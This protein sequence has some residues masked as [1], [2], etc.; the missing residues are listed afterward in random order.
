[1]TQEFDDAVMLG[2]VKTP[3]AKVET[4]FGAALKLGI[5]RLNSSMELRK[6]IVDIAWFEVLDAFKKLNLG[7]TVYEAG[8]HRYLRHD[9]QRFDVLVNVDPQ[10][11][12]TSESPALFTVDGPRPGEQE[13]TVFFK[14]TSTS[15]RMEIDCLR[16]ELYDYFRNPATGAILNRLIKKS[17]P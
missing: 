15:C 17:K 1:M 6:A 3:E 7:I 2:R 5:E 14:A 9:E 4:D 8:L 10:L 13:F 12:R 16:K 11:A